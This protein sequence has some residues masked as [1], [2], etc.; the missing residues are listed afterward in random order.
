MVIVIFHLVTSPDIKAP[1]LKATSTGHII[2]PNWT[3]NLLI[4][5]AAKKPKTKDKG[6]FLL[7][8]L[9]YFAMLSNVL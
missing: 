1:T 4:T 5:V 9:Q 3:Q 7:N 2:V 8:S 6:S